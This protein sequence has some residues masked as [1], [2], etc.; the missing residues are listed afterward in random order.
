MKALI[1]YRNCWYDSY[2]GAIKLWTWDN[3][4]NRIETEHTFEPYL[5]LESREKKDATSI[6]N[7]PLRKISFQKQFDRF[8]FVKDCGTNRI[9]YNLNCEQQFLIDTFASSVDDPDFAQFPLRT[10]FLDIEVHSPDEFPDP[11]EVKH[12]INIITVYDSLTDKVYTWGLGEYK[13]REFSDVVYI[14]C[15]SERILLQTFLGFW[16]KNYPDCLSYWFGEQFDLPYIINRLNRLFGENGANELSPVGK[17]R[18]REDIVNK[19][20]QTFDKWTISGISCIDYMEAYKTYARGLKASYNLNAI[21]EEELG[22]GKIAYNAVSLAQLADTDWDKFVDYNIQDVLLLKK[23]DAK[24]KYLS[25]IRQLAYRGCTTFEKA[26]GKVEMVAGAVAIQAKNSNQVIPTFKKKEVDSDYEG[27]YVRDPT[28]GFH[29]DVVSFDA[30]SL[31]PNTIITLNISPETKVGKIVD[32]T[33]T[34]VTVLLV[35]GKSHEM[36]IEQFGKW[37]DTERLSISR[38][39]VLYSQKKK[40]LMP[41]VLDS[42]YTKRVNTRKQAKVIETQLKELDKNSEEY[43]RL[44]IQFEQL[45]TL[46]NTYKLFMN[47]AYGAFANQHFPFFDLDHASSITL[48]GQWIIKGSAEIVNEHINKL[49]NTQ[50]LNFAIAGDTDSIFLSVHDLLKYYNVN[51]QDKNGVTKKALKIIEDIEDALSKGITDW[52]KNILKSKDPRIVF[53][54]ETICDNALFLEK[55]RYIAHIIDAEGLKVSKFKYVGGDIVSSATPPV[56]K[57]LLKRTVETA[58]M[59]QDITEVNQKYKLAYDEFK[60]FTINDLAKRGGVNGLTKYGEGITGFNFKSKTPSHVK[61]A[62]SYNYLL[63]HFN[64]ENK[65]EPIKD[66]SKIK[67]FPCVTNPFGIEEIAYLDQLPVEFGLEMN[68]DKLFKKLCESMIQSVYETVGWRLPDM[69]NQAETDLTALFS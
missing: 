38:A 52:C 5:Y 25:I 14:N 15:P 43:K 21:A 7:T 31:Y 13:N 63:K 51:I 56:I 35:S 20:G 4:G 49:M 53:K 2:K 54:R 64:I 48:T 44:L 69:I 8:K 65:Y 22:E 47:S 28:R 27:A 3:S 9:F 60:K 16:K 26:L 39:K 18:C 50:G 42:M 62:L 10:F 6:Y 41:D 17:L 29:K 45:D 68:Y 66:G 36:T 23:L 1:M 61:A 40:G 11:K 30:N 34:H 46:Q 57:R 33:D 12:P 24:L 59:T 58:V 55:K 19:I 32:K 67:R 37:V